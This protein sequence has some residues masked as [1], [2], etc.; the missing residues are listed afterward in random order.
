MKSFLPVLSISFLLFVAAAC[1]PQKPILWKVTPTGLAGHSTTVLGNPSQAAGRGTAT[2]VA[3]DGVD[4]G[5]VTSFNEI[6]NV[7]EFTVE[8]IFKPRATTTAT[9]REQ[10]LVHIEDPA[11]PNR[12]LSLELRITDKNQWQAHFSVKSDNGQLNL[13]DASKTHPLDKWATMTLVY[14]DKKMTGYVN[15]MPEV[16]GELEFLPL[17]ASA[18]TS[19]GA[20]VDQRNWF[21]GE[22]ETVRF[23]KT[24]LLPKK[25]SE[26]IPSTTR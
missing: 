4:D 20:S 2:A 16:N 25:Y 10:H 21:N 7:D 18:K 22:I 23:F 15:G 5:L 13:M 8:V 1:T 19:I 9:N 14:K 3:F 6:A 12:R 17:P 26:G 11:N 24:A